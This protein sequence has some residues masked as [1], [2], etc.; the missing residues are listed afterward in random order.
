M[1]PRRM[2]QNIVEAIAEYER[3]RPNLV[4]DGGN[5]RGA[6]GNARG[7]GGNFGGTEG[8]ARG[9]AGGNI[10]PDVHSISKCSDEDRVKYDVCTLHGCALTWRNDNVHTFGIDAANRIPWNELQDMMT[11][12][13]CSRTEIQKID[14][15]L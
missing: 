12:K 14:Q 8:N 4:G 6:G 9:N 5:T 15:E 2:N 3:N 7:V 10:T 11:A 13:Y 1:P